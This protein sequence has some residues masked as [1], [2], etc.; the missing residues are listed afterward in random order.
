VRTLALSTL[1]LSKLADRKQ[2]HRLEVEFA[3]LLYAVTLAREIAGAQRLCDPEEAAVCTLFRFFGRLVVALYRYEFYEQIVCLSKQER[4]SENQAAVRVLGL[5]L[6]KIGMEL[7]SRWGM[8]A[9]IV[10]ALAPCPEPI[11]FNT[12]VEARLQTLAAFCMQLTLT[13]RQPA[14][15]APRQNIEALLQ[16]FGP[17]L[18]LE[19]Q[20]LKTHLELVDL[21][22][23]EISQALGLAVCP[24]A[25]E[26][27]DEAST[28]TFSPLNRPQASLVLRAGLVT[29]NRMLSQNEP[30]DSTLKRVCDILHRPFA[31][32]RVSVF[33]AL[34]QQTLSLRA[35]AGKPTNVDSATECLRFGAQDNIVRDA[36]LNNVDFYIR[37][38][39]DWRGQSWEHWFS[40][41]PDAKS[42]VLLPTVRE[43]LQLRLIYADHSSSNVQG[44]IQGARVRPTQNMQKLAM[45]FR[46]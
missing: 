3:G 36:L 39:S 32:Q 34:S 40:V 7:L 8:P 28:L 38:S 35:Q 15:I 12:C 4:I 33:C 2:A 25:G 26:V 19:R 30:S 29:L 22:A 1:L 31:F 45:R 20:R 46:A 23:Q 10:H 9:R 24:I 44:W 43:N 18:R 13:L 37:S 16:R 17:A 42:F 21:Q 11:R 27:F 14:L 41:F 5:G 6:D